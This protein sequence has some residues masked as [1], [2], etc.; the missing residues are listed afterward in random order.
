MAKNFETKNLKILGKDL[1]KIYFEKNLI[2]GNFLSKKYIKKRLNRV[3]I[4]G[5]PP[6]F[7]KICGKYVK[8]PK[9]V[10]LTQQWV[11]YVKNIFHIFT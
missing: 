7:A 8:R 9:Y 2:I 5:F 11:K 10:K 6:D 4:W 3:K 1:K